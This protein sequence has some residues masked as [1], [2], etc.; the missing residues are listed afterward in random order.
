MHN[1]FQD[2][3]KVPIQSTTGFQLGRDRKVADAVNVEPLLLFSLNA[4]SDLFARPSLTD[5]SQRYLPLSRAI[6]MAH[7]CHLV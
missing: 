6:L 7:A 3:V 2:F 4:D 5:A 1:P